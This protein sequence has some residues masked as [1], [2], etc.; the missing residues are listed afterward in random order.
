MTTI[1]TVPE[2]SGKRPPIWQRHRNLSIAAVVLVIA[3]I[4]VLT[5]LPTSTSR[6]SDISA[7]RA[8][9]SEVNSDLQP[10]AYSVH[11]ALSIW[12][13]ASTHRLSAADRAPTPGLLSDDQSACSLT[14]QSVYDLASNI[15]PPTTAAGKQLGQL[16]NT[17]TLWTT[18]DALQA[19]EDVQA[20]MNKPGNVAALNGLKK[21]EAQ[22]ARDRQA[23]LSQEAAADRDLDTHL[24]PV[25]LPAEPTNGVSS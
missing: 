12:A 23:A 20:L 21:E 18:S 13:L 11:Q 9:M 6:A 24:A 22:M 16:I 10:C 25:D 3:L 15:Q 2:A 5:D 4:T 14:N 19:V 17:A 1:E 8:V 7:E